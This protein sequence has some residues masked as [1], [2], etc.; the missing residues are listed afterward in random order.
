VQQNKTWTLGTKEETRND[1]KFWQENI[2]INMNVK[3]EIKHTE[4]NI[5]LW[6][7]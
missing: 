7:N 4:W 6:W 1:T 3:E 5:I 2:F